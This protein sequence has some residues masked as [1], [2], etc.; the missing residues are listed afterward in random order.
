[1][2]FS[3][4]EG[5]FREEFWPWFRLLLLG[6]SVICPGY[7]PRQQVVLQVVAVAVVAGVLAVEGVVVAVVAAGVELHLRFKAYN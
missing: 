5:S 4:G 1:M 7:G 2:T 6:L 3:A